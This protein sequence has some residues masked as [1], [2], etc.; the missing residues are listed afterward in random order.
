[1]KPSYPF[2]I[3]LSG[4]FL[5]LIVIVLPA[6]ARETTWS[7][8]M[9]YQ[10]GVTSSSIWSVIPDVYNPTTVPVWPKKNYIND[11]IEFSFNKNSTTPIPNCTTTVYLTITPHSQG[12]V[13]LP[14]ITQTLQIDYNQAANTTYHD[15]ATYT[16]SDVWEFDVDVT[17][18][19]TLDP[20]GNVIPTPQVA[21]EGFIQGDFY[22]DFDCGHLTDFISTSYNVSNHTLTVTWAPY[23]NADDYDL[24]WTFVDDID[25]DC[26]I[27]L[28]PGH[29]PSSALTYNFQDNCTRINTK[30]THYDIS[31]V[32]PTGY[33]LYRVRSVG[34]NI[35]NT[36]QRIE[37]VWSSS[38]PTDLVGNFPLNAQYNITNEEFE[39]YIDW[40]YEADFSEGG[41]KK[42][43]VSYFDGTLRNRQTVNRLSTNHKVLVQET[44]YDHY[45]RNAI[46]VL[47]APDRRNDVSS[48]PYGDQLAYH[49]NFNLATNGSWPY[50][51]RDFDNFNNC[52]SGPNYG[53]ISAMISTSG[54]SNY[55][56]N[57]NP[58]K[59][60]ENNFIP[61]A[62]NYPFT[63]TKYTQDNTN[64]IESQS[65]AGSGYKIGSGHETQYFYSTPEQTEL[66]MLFTDNVGFNSHYKKILMRDPN[67]Q[68]SVTYKDM[69]GKVIATA[70][71]GQ[72]PS[73]LNSITP[74]PNQTIPATSKSPLNELNK[75]DYSAN[76]IVMQDIIKVT[77]PHS[78]YTVEYSVDV[79][80]LKLCESDNYCYNCQYNLSITLTD[81]CNVDKITPNSQI[82]IGTL[83]LGTCTGAT[84]YPS[85]DVQ[86]IQVFLDPGE[87]TLTKILTVDPDAIEDNVKQYSDYLDG[88]DKG[89]IT[90]SCNIK[91]SSDFTAAY[92]DGGCGHHTPGMPGFC[93]F[94]KKLLL[95]DVNPRLNGQYAGYKTD[96][97]HL[98]GA[99]DY[100][101]SI[102]N[103]HNQLPGS[104]RSNPYWR[105]PLNLLDN[106][107]TQNA[108]YEPDPANPGNL[109]R[110][111][112]E[113][114]GTF[115]NETPAVKDH[116]LANTF[117]DNGKTYV[118]PENLYDY[119]TFVQY[120]EDSWANSLFAYHP[121]YCGYQ[122]CTNTENS[123]NQTNTILGINTYDEAHANGY[124]NPLT[125]SD[126]LFSN[127]YY[128][129]CNGGTVEAK[130]AS[131]AIEFNNQLSNFKGTN[132]DMIYVAILTVECPNCTV[133]NTNPINPDFY[134]F[135]TPEGIDFD[136][137]SHKDQL[138]TACERDAVWEA[139]RAMLLGAKS[140]A[141]YNIR[142]ALIQC[143][144]GY[145]GSF[146]DAPYK[147]KIQR[148]GTAWDFMDIDPTSDLESAATDKA[149]N[150][151]DDQ[152]KTQ[153][154]AYG[155]QWRDMLLQCT[156]Y[157]PTGY[158]DQYA[159]KTDVNGKPADDI[160]LI[161]IPALSNVCQGGC[162]LTH[163]FGSSNNPHNGENFKS[164]LDNYWRTHIDANKDF[165][166]TDKC[167]IDMIKM[168]P[169][170]DQ[171]I[172][173]GNGMIAMLDKCA[174]DKVLKAI[175]DLTNNTLPQ[176]C[177]G[178]VNPTAADVFM[179]ENNLSLDDFTRI[180]CLCEDAWKLGY[181]TGVWTATDQWQQ[182]SIDQLARDMYSVPNEITCT[183]CVGCKQV[184]DA[185][186]DYNTKNPGLTGYANY[187]EMVA[188]HLN[189]L[190]G[191]NLP[192]K[193]YLEF[194]YHCMQVSS[195]N[196]TQVSAIAPDV[197]HLLGYIFNGSYSQLKLGQTM[198]LDQSYMTASI[199]LGNT[200]K[201]SPYFKYLQLDANKFYGTI[202]DKCGFNCEITITPRTGETTDLSAVTLTGPIRASTQSGTG[203]YDF[204][205]QGLVNGNPVWLAGYT[206]CFDMISCPAP[207]EVNVCA[208]NAR[209]DLCVYD[210][211]T[212]LSNDVIIDN[213]ESRS[214]T[215]FLT[216][217]QD[218][219]N[220]KYGHDP[221]YDATLAAE[222]AT[223]KTDLAN[224]LISLSQEDQFATGILGKIAWPDYIK[225]KLL[226]LSS[227][228]TVPSFLSCQVCKTCGDINAAVYD[229]EQLSGFDG[230]SGSNLV[231]PLQT[232]LNS[233]LGFPVN[234]TYV[235]SNNGEIPQDPDCP[236]CNLND[237]YLVCNQVSLQA[238]DLQRLLNGMA[239]NN[240]LFSSIDVKLYIG[241]YNDLF[242][243]S[244]LYIKHNCNRPLFSSLIENDKLFIHI[245]DERGYNC[246]IQL[247]EDGCFN[248][249]KITSFSNI[250]VDQQDIGENKKFTIKVVIDG[251]T[252]TLHGSSDCYTISSCCLVNTGRLCNKIKKQ[253]TT[254]KDDC[255]DKLQE[256]SDYQKAKEYK[257]YKDGLIKA[258]RENY[259]KHCMDNATE[260]INLTFPYHIYH[261][262]L[263]YYDQAGNLVQTVPPMGV[264][265]ADL[266]NTTAGLANE[267]SIDN[268]RRHPGSYT[269]VAEGHHQKTIY[270]YNTLNKVNYNSTPDAGITKMWYDLLARP[271]L[272]QN[273]NQQLNSQYTFSMYDP[274][275]RVT[276]TGQIT[277]SGT[278]LPLSATNYFGSYQAAL[279]SFLNV[280]RSQVVYTQYDEKFTS[281]NGVPANLGLAQ[282]NLRGRVASVMYMESEG[283]ISYGTHY[284]YDELG[285]VSD[286]YQQIRELSQLGK[287]FY[288]IHYDYDVI[289]GKVNLVSYEENHPDQFFHKYEYDADNRVISV[290]TSRNKISWAQDAAYK[291]YLHGPL[292]RTELGDQQVQGIDYAYTLQGWIKGV[293]SN[294][295]N[296]SASDDMGL[297]GVPGSATK[298]FGR[299]AYGFTMGYNNNDYKPIGGGA[300]HFETGY[301]DFCNNTPTVSP[302]LFNGNIRS[303][304][305]AIGKFTPPG[306]PV[307]PVAYAYTYDQLN[308]LV[309]ADFFK[310]PGPGP[311]M[312]KTEY[313]E[314]FAYDENGNISSL[315]RNGYNPNQ[316]MDQLTYTYDNS[317]RDNI[318]RLL[319]IT[320]VAS[321]TNYVDDIK[322]QSSGN[323]GYDHIGN[324]TSDQAE[325]ISSITWNVYNKITSVVHGSPS[326]VKPDLEFHYGPDGNRVVK[327]D[328]PD[329]SN[330]LTWK[331]T[332]HVRDA[333]GN[334]MAT[335]TRAVSDIHTLNSDLPT[336]TNLVNS[337]VNHIRIDNFSSFMANNFATNTGF[338]NGL[339][340]DLSSGDLNTVLITCG[341]HSQPIR[342]NILN[343][344]TADEMAR[345]SLQQG[346]V[347]DIVNLF[348]TNNGNKQS[349]VENM[350]QGT[351]CTSYLLAFATVDQSAFNAMYTTYSGGSSSTNAAKAADLCALNSTVHSAMATDMISNHGASTKSA[352][353]GCNG[354]DLY[355]AMHAF[356]D[357]NFM[358]TGM[359]SITGVPALIQYFNS[360]NHSLLVSN[361]NSITP[362]TLINDDKSVFVKYAIMFNQNL[363]AQ[364][365]VRINENIYD[366][367][368]LWFP[369]TFPM[370]LV[371]EV[372]GDM[373][374]SLCDYHEDF[375]LA[376]LDIYG[377]KRVGLQKE[378]LKIAATDYLGQA[379]SSGM[380]IY[381]IC[382]TPQAL[383]MPGASY[384]QL[385]GMKRYE[386]TNHL[387]NVLVTI[388][389]RKVPAI[390]APGFSDADVWTATD[391][392][393][394]GS[395]MPGYLAS[396]PGL[397]RSWQAPNE[398]YRFGF[399]GKEHDN[400]FRNDN[401]TPGSGLGNSYDYG[402]RIYDPR[403]G[404]WMACDPDAKKYPNMQPYSYAA[405]NPIVFI[406]PDGKRVEA[407]QTAGE[408]AVL[409]DYINRRTTLLFTFDNNGFLQVVPNGINNYQ[410]PKSQTFTDDLVGLIPIPKKLTLFIATA[411][412][413]LDPVTG[414]PRIDP[415]TKQPEKIILANSGGGKTV[416]GVGG[417]VIVAINNQP[418]SGI[419]DQQGNTLTAQPDDILAHEIV[420]H[421]APEMLHKSAAGTGDAV[422]DENV[423]RS[424]LHQP[425][426]QVIPTGQQGHDD[427]KF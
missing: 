172:F 331:Y 380:V 225:Y 404:R 399:N 355:N 307:I 1:M 157:V 118:Y 327:I 74:N 386:L 185:I 295:L 230:L 27:C 423:M 245:T 328:K 306:A 367:N 414:K 366:F 338:V 146:K 274:L 105:N 54:A 275:G 337:L 317:S 214:N 43:I 358:K 112:F 210:K 132:Y 427:E 406:D 420:G 145:S 88:V 361:I 64:R 144:G 49:I 121:E 231:T 215:D 16:F 329:P 31:L 393:A 240:D 279:T 5:I 190:F 339:Q 81:E 364:E 353:L 198:N 6:S 110:S 156:D 79:D 243:N 203:P 182:V 107:P 252:K 222:L 103:D 341:D 425:L 72:N 193:S 85:S 304:S 21:V 25:P 266:S 97:D 309:N 389:D 326:S 302:E 300:A 122:W 320:D 264:A 229:F 232:H 258:F 248:A 298:D 410:G 37:G 340:A 76:Q 381:S 238:M 325:G 199:Y 346:D 127:N 263:Y 301:S 262:T 348:Y 219:F 351:R 250:Q 268:Y 130:K 55:Y 161:I 139:Y 345:V 405:E 422:D 333:Q 174:C 94:S 71:A 233:E 359:Q 82:K 61:D 290:S 241:Y 227:N 223:W 187:P 165:P 14:T 129:L 344:Y 376:E 218:A 285:Y 30:E 179:C 310:Y 78:S 119:K 362:V 349:L 92:D 282:D 244:S 276:E 19:I 33:L 173:G 208:G 297:D 378:N 38:I 96:P 205:I 143:C 34:H 102:L 292:A 149:K 57:L 239:A 360:D 255:H 66:D 256:L 312:P 194:N 36:T 234:V 181:P 120:W 168:P 260:V 402:A 140:I 226:E 45:G 164:V 246:T 152:C 17:N 247:Q 32:F 397:G 93:D 2:L 23:V 237:N 104:V 350:L 372:Q 131:E 206:T 183:R 322:N 236:E 91:K 291:Y 83:S 413:P 9:V 89:T 265:V 419:K 155:A 401:S 108:Y 41:K 162:D 382:G 12:G 138:P 259:I 384:Q 10:T 294:S 357:F 417:D 409:L 370:D 87:Y 293:N 101:L 335:Y 426:R 158:L 153:C 342:N 411:I 22:Y 70:L 151:L 254:L 75:K 392:Y 126:Y 186:L 44:I 217:M 365:L 213:S 35:A 135:K 371:T 192:G 98:N 415:V 141:E 123:R 289:S 352:L 15:M 148:F 332:Y 28:N 86:S 154:D 286:L 418:Y 166:Q 189:E 170:Y 209:I 26:Q 311:W 288:K 200:T 373:H 287:E 408:R 303:M 116:L 354:G 398:D 319:F 114:T 396:A 369:P 280:S 270:Q 42:E 281:L 80:P 4:L 24:E 115:P 269:A 211:F 137:K 124:I 313:H 273:A 63:Q 7:N 235:S 395:P 99:S 251:V 109:I 257:D 113:V 169:G 84:R 59:T 167:H 314:D 46:N 316:S 3:K 305:T 47:P 347:T 261:F 224:A 50:S 375:T 73:T 296:I 134:I 69:N 277:N 216:K 52:P 160:D 128:S 65:N 315:T 284:S 117:Q 321:A 368:R 48:N 202:T 377:Q 178:L 407:P 147:D 39:P 299:D 391:Y 20:S 106:V 184:N 133:K 204:E 343:Y 18:I 272:V 40:R 336:Y 111:K 196:C 308:R 383:G 267:A 163:P 8:S 374:V 390:G 175:N 403:V 228:Y 201:C 278:Q 363:A 159:Y 56:S 379:S 95:K 249:G 242:V 176:S 356:T 207:P 53:N 11:R 323:Y 51:S 283:S 29:L 68:L 177:S 136:L 188:H 58:I 171:N 271:V 125:Y 318:N 62:E 400:E 421:A 180:T 220:E 412:N 221:A 424:E 195:Q 100:P 197:Q 142:K 150:A 67:G 324:I 387:G 60:N 330:A 388:S 77:E 191:L 334:I 416:H 253:T 90:N 394:F 13:T 212:E 385:L